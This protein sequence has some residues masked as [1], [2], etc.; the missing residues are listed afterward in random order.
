MRSVK[1]RD[2][3]VNLKLFRQKSST[4]LKHESLISLKIRAPDTH[5][6]EGLSEHNVF[7]ISASTWRAL[8][9]ARFAT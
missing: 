8:V 1:L 9:T 5:F 6:I 4:S 7:L 3:T 2:A